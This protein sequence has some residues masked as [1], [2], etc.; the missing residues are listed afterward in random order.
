L[1]RARRLANAANGTGSAPHA[2]DTTS[3]SAGPGCCGAAWHL[4]LLQPLLLL[5]PQLLHPLLELLL[6]L[7]Q[8]PPLPLQLL[9]LPPELL[10]PPL[11]L[12]PLLVPPPLDEHA[13]QPLL[14]PHPLS[15]DSELLQLGPLQLQLGDAWQFWLLLHEFPHDTLVVRGGVVDVPPS[16]PGNVVA[17]GP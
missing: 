16:S 13:S 7:L 14:P 1:R 8:L 3:A 2:I 10:E 12:P 15:H 4:P 17:G 6:Q 5:P 11:Q 9:Q